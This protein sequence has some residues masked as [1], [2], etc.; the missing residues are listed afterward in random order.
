MYN[1]SFITEE[2][3]PMTTPRDYL[4]HHHHNDMV[5]ADYRPDAYRITDVDLY[6]NLDK[7]ETKVRSRMVVEG[8]PK[9]PKQGGP[10]VLQ[11]EDV[12]LVSVKIKD[13]LRWRQLD[14]AD[15]LVDE[16]QLIIKRPPTGR[17][18]LEV[19]NEI[20]PE[21][22]TKLS[23]I[24]AS[25]DIIGSQCESQGFRRITYYLDRP[26][27][28]ARFTTT[29]E[30]DKKKYPVLISNG[31]GD[32]TKT[33]DL[34]NGRHRIKWVDPWPKPSYLFATIAGDMEVISDT[35]I[36]CS[37]KK[38]DIH[39]VV[40]KGYENKVDF[41]LKFIKQAM[42]WDEDVYSF[43]YDLDVLHLIGLEKFNMGAMEN[44]GAIVFNIKDF[45]GDAETCTD[46]QL[47][48]IRSVNGH[49]YQHDLTG[50]RVTVRDW[51]EISL[52]ESLT[53]LRTEQFSGDMGSH[54]IETID[55]AAYLRNV[56]FREDAGPTAHCVRPER[57]E[58]FDNIY[59]PTVYNKGARVLN[60]LKNIIGEE[61]WY[62]GMINY[63][64]KFDGQ[65][66]T[67][68]DFVE[69]MQDTSG[70]NLNQFFRWYT[71]S[72]TPEVSYEGKYDAQAKTY[73]LTLKQRTPSTPGQPEESKKPF[74]IPV[75]VGL[76]GQ[77]GNDIELKIKGAKADAA[78]T[79][80]LQLTKEEQTF[81]FENVDGPVVPSILRDFSAPV[82]ITTQPSDDELAFRIAH[83]SDAFSR[84]DAWDVL[85]SSAMKKLLKD[86]EAGKEL[87]LPQ[88]IVDAFG[89]NLAGALEGDKSLSARLLGL[90]AFTRDL[91]G[92][93]PV[94][95]LEVSRFVSKTL[96]ETFKDE[97][98]E[99]Y[100][101]TTAPKGEA[102]DISPEQV[103]R[104]ELHNLSLSFLGRL[105]G[106]E[107]LAEAQ[108]AQSKNMTEKLGSL[109]V[110]AKDESPTAAAALESFYKKFRKDTNVMDT[111]LTVSAQVQGG[112]AAGRV[113]KLMESDVFDMTN[114]NK[115]RALMSGFA[116]NIEAFHNKDG[117]GYKLLADT[118]ITL[119]GVNPHTATGIIRPL[120]D[121]KRYDEARQKLILKELARIRKTP[122]LDSQ[123]KDIVGKALAS[124]EAARPQSK[125]ASP[126]AA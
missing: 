111:W 66:I 112:D 108:Y 12:D 49:E 32:L 3:L 52:K 120:A 87:K 61:M 15:F 105:P 4:F 13:G 54:A 110:V 57:V 37:G 28:L 10:L 78:T 22:N 79:C 100:N 116:S 67:V 9:S 92:Y 56:Q 74:H 26:D 17:F 55:N 16:N 59:S 60:A 46:E 104:R 23:G 91:A 124:A 83:D 33:K 81:V 21:E 96:A 30:A 44:K 11:G 20:N 115:V 65:A 77:D 70:V 76:I 113:Q 73:S 80:M 62:K 53:E 89:A 88:N 90:P 2:I 84:F 58:A 102:Y 106:N 109:R 121:F 63:L 71:Q 75:A 27:N 31:N 8:N 5:R 40:P 93:D 72:G 42:K 14:R 41:S 126:K 38:V 101:K 7:T 99:L 43:E 82:K 34:G 95:A 51:F 69:N 107:A 68:D 98:S 123:I 6:I 39:A 18:E 24:Y 25:G 47:R 85:M 36:T 119:N 97:F 114:P 125:G 64:K 50:N 29:L 86:K 1:F 94:A 117:S 19:V 45:C 48:R 118:I 122:E 103:G 35:F